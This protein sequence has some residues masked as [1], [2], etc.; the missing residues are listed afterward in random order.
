MPPDPWSELLASLPETPLD[1]CLR[2][3]ALQKP[4]HIALIDRGLRFTYAALDDRVSR[5]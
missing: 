1:A 2:R 5:L 3:H 4:D